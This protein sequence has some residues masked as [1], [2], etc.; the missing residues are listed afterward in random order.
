MLGIF[1]SRDQ[2]F[3]VIPH[4]VIVTWSP[5]SYGSHDFSFVEFHPL[6]LSIPPD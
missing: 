2:P 5:N 3:H 1:Q 6:A 4:D